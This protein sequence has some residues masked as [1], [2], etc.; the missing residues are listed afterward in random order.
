MPCRLLNLL[1]VLSL[2][3][4][5]ASAALFVRSVWVTDWVSAAT[6]RF[7]PGDY[8]Y[9]D[10]VVASD[11][12]GLSV[13]WNRIFRSDAGNRASDLPPGRNMRLEADRRPAGA[14]LRRSLRFRLNRHRYGDGSGRR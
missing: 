12:G 6:V 14:S 13:E 2:V 4:C 11:A 7:D 8:H 3:T 1:T 10:W 9:L 5:G